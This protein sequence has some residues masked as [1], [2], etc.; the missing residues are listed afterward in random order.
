MT[1][2]TIRRLTAVVAAALLLP[3]AGTAKSIVTR[4][5]QEQPAP[6]GQDQR[7]PPPQPQAGQPADPTRGMTPEQRAR[8]CRDHPG[9]C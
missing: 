2:G 9:Q 8:W 3:A 6:Q 4:N 1:S 7:N 5:G